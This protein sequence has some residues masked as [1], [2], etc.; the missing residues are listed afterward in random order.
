MTIKQIYDFALQMGLKADLRGQTKVKENLKRLRQKYASLSEEAK[1]RFDENRLINPYMDSQILHLPKNP[2]KPVKKI[3]VGIDIGVSE[4]LLAD[5]LGDI[6]LII[7]HHPLG[8]G[9]AYLDD[10]MHLQAEVLAQ[11]GVPI[12]I[13]EKLMKVRISEVARSVSKSNQYRV[14]DAAKLLDTGLICLHTVCDNLVANLLKSKIKKANPQ[15]LGDLMKLL[16]TIPEYSEA[17]KMGMGP[18]LFVGQEDSHCGKIAITEITGGTEGN[19]KLFDK[20]AQA[21]IGTVVGMHVSEEHRK[22]AEAAHIN[23]VIAGHMSSDSVGLN[24]L[25]DQLKKKGI[26]IVPCSGLIRSI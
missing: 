18:K 25:L 17:E 12:N 10:V 24:I 4:I 1:T 3:M 22:Q 20:M 6:D 15:Y 21:G 14:V 5:K 8:K 2:Y 26:S 19:P 16:R 11:Y 23:V 13:S 9:L 7:G